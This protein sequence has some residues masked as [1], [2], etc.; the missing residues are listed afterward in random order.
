MK[1]PDTKTAFSQHTHNGKC[2]KVTFQ[3]PQKNNRTNEK[4]V[5]KKVTPK[6]AI[7]DDSETDI[8]IEIN[9]Q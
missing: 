6:L 5:I 2:P 9:I 1:I 7:S 8:S 3:N 4:T